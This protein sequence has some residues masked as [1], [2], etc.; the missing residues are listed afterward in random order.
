MVGQ[1]EAA[2]KMAVLASKVAAM[3]PSLDDAAAPR[4][5]TRSTSHRVGKL[6]EWTRG[7]AM[8]SHRHSSKGAE[9][10]AAPAEVVEAKVD[11][12]RV[13]GR[14]RGSGR[15]GPAIEAET[16]AERRDDSSDSEDR[17]Q[18]DETEVEEIELK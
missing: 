5:A 13:P 18:I 17:G 3:D 8:G 11:G 7:A 10:E 4:T 9:E 16:E 1:F 14:T 15:A 2:H 12:E 6:M